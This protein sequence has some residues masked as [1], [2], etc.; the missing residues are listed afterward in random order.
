MVLQSFKNMKQKLRQLIGSFAGSS[1][2]FGMGQALLLQAGAQVLEHRRLLANAG[3]RVEGLAGLLE[4]MAFDASMYL[5]QDEGLLADAL[6]T[7]SEALREA[8]S[9]MREGL[10]QVEQPAGAEKKV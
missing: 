7:R 3:D 8:V 10:P 2:R 5:R 1:Q 4:D 9:S 6:R